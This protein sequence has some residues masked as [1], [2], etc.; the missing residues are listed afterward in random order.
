M[1]VG[2]VADWAMGAIE[3]RTGERSQVGWAGGC[4]GIVLAED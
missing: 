4:N 2:G 3:G 1:G